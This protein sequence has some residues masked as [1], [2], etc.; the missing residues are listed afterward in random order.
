MSSEDERNR[1]EN[2]VLGLSNLQMRAL[3]DSIT[4]LMNTCLEQ[5][6]Q[7]LDEIQTSQQTRPRPGARRDRPRLPNPSD[8]EV[9][10]EDFEDDVRSTNRPRR[11]HRNREQGDINQFARTDRVNDSLGGL[12]L[13]SPTLMARMIQMLFLNGKENLSLFLIVKT[14]LILRKLSWPQLNLLA[15]LLIGMIKL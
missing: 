5:I 13:K 14:S 3:N 4:N 8:D 6:H 15:M 10:E 9:Q 11:G 7:R 12:K 1:P 2:Y